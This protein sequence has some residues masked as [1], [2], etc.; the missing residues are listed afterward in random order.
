M[1]GVPWFDD[2]GET[3]NAHGGCVVSH[4][5]RYYL[6]GE[7]KT[8]DG[9]HFAGF[10]RYTSP[11]L[12]TW[13]YDGMAMPPQPR[14]LLGPGRIG[15]R[16]KVV[17]RSGGGFAL[18]AHSDDLTYTDPVTVVALAEHIDEEFTLHGPLLRD[19]EPLR[20]WDIGTFEDDDGEAYLLVHEGDIHRLTPD[21]TAIAETIATGLCPGGESPAMAAQEG[22]YYLMFSGKTSWERNDNRYL[23]AQDL[24]GPWHPGGLLAP[25]GSLTHNS[26]CGF[27]LRW[28]GDRGRWIYLGDRW[29]Y[30]RQASAATY[31]WLPLEWGQAEPLAEYLPAWDPASLARVDPGGRVIPAAFDSGESGA[32]WEAEFRGARVGL[33]GIC[34]PDGGY[35]DIEIHAAG[36]VRAKATV[37][38]YANIPQPGLRYLSP[39]L[40]DGEHTVRV[41]VTGHSP[42]WSDKTRA[43]YGSTGARVTITGMRTWPSPPH[44][45]P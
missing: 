23:W 33:E 31:V 4:G 28:P 36:R 2:R 29:S 5:G 39:H 14:G 25:A 21:R 34:T 12:V 38:F 37:D 20:R 45:T 3:V 16:V 11:D 43:R 44:L 30:P 15:E 41:R 24:S 1:N 17:H 9:N 7:Y 22:M 32:V 10:A 13:T 8:D 19:G 42:T 27:A 26:Q 35:A 6:F 18:L 40:P